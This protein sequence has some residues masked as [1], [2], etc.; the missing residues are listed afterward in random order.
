MIQVI[1][2]GGLCSSV[3]V[4]RPVLDHAG[5]FP[6]H[7]INVVHWSVGLG[8]V[9]A[10]LSISLMWI[11]GALRW[12]NRSLQ[13]LIWMLLLSVIYFALSPWWR[14]Q[15][16]VAHALCLLGLLWLWMDSYRARH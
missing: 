4:A 14:L 8:I 7:G 2:L 15:M 16:M 11:Q 9:G 3:Y 12:T 5:F 6:L 10:I 13:I 1:W